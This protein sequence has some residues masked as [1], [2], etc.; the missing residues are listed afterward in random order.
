MRR[1][2]FA[3]VLITAALCI[4]ACSG[5]GAAVK[6][7]SAVGGLPGSSTAF[8]TASAFSAKEKTDFL[9][10]EAR[11]LGSTKGRVAL[12]VLINRLDSTQQVDD[13]AKMDASELF[14]TLQDTAAKKD[15]SLEAL[16]RQYDLQSIL[17]SEGIYISI[18][19]N[20]VI[21]SPSSAETSDWAS[22]FEQAINSNS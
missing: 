1:Y 2:I 9:T 7:G 10:E 12:A 11:R 14:S 16:N 5:R 17:A 13:L 22:Q 21:S 18:Q 6:S 19:A 4:S 15:Q 8:L 20:D 3:A